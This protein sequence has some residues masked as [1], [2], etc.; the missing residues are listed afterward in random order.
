MTK[1]ISPGHVPRC[2]T[3]VKAKSVQA[4]KSR[5]AATTTVHANRPALYLRMN[6]QVKDISR[7]PTNPALRQSLVCSILSVH[8]LV[9]GVQPRPHCA[10]GA[11]L[12]PTRHNDDRQPPL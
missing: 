10:N 4:M 7:L 9:V 8:S 2:Q 3:L 12:Q 6:I 11:S 1:A 5:F